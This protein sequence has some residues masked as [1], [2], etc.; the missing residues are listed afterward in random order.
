MPYQVNNI[1]YNK[2]FHLVRVPCVYQN[3][4]SNNVPVLHQL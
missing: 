3:N 1:Y 4:I 2:S